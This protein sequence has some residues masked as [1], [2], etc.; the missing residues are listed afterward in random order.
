MNTIYHPHNLIAKNSGSG[1]DPKALTLLNPDNL[2]LKLLPSILPRET[3]FSG[4]F[5]ENLNEA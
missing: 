2:I 3:I 5:I 1:L 4:D